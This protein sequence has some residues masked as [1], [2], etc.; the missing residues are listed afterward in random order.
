MSLIYHF[1]QKMIIYIKKEASIRY[2]F[3]N[4][5]Y[6]P[7]NGCWTKNITTDYKNENRLGQNTFFSALAICMGLR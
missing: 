4:I 2:D 1:V 3:Q 6:S 5:V 7:K